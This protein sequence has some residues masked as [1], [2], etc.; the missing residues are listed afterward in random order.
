M[1]NLLHLGIMVSAAGL[2]WASN[3]AAAAGTDAIL[4][5]PEMTEELCATVSPDDLIW[6]FFPDDEHPER[7]V[8]PSLAGIDR[9]Y[10]AYAIRLSALTDRKY[11]EAKKTRETVVK[12]FN[13]IHLSVVTAYGGSGAHDYER[14]PGRIEWLIHWGWRY[15]F[16]GHISRYDNKQVRSAILLFAAGYQ[17]SDEQREKMIS[18]IDAGLGYLDELPE[19]QRPYYRNHLMHLV[20]SYFGS[21]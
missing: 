18:A 12:A 7:P 17:V 2:F 6:R 13:A 21:R 5:Y 15:G 11:P 3:L 14:L 8:N 9:F 10:E 4:A 20:G 16:D 1:A 19:N